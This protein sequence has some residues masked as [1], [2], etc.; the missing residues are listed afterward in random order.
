[1]SNNEKNLVIYYS[2]KN[3]EGITILWCV[4]ILL[5]VHLISRLASTFSC[6][7][8]YAFT[9]YWL[10]NFHMHLIQVMNHIVDWFYLQC[11][12]FHH[13]IYQ[14]TNYVLTKHWCEPCI[15]LLIHHWVS[16]WWANHFI[17]HTLMWSVTSLKGWGRLVANC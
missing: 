9:Q 16:K 11:H 8:Y 13:V 14:P 3:I 10:L 15:L 12:Y 2:T 17:V 7:I 6:T 5:F 1:M 4:L